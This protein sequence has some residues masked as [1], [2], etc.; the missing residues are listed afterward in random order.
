MLEFQEHLSLR[1]L[2]GNPSG[3]DDDLIGGWLFL[4]ASYCL[5]APVHPQEEGRGRA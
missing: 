1:F 3:N 4:L 2:K 5:L